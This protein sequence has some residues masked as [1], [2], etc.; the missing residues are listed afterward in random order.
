[1]RRAALV[2]LTSVLAGCGSGGDDRPSREEARTCL[3]RLDL[4]VTP[5]ERSPNDDDGPYAKLDANDVLKG[6]VR[7][8]AAYYDDERDAERVQPAA[9]RAAR[10]VDGVV[11]RHGSVT[12]LWIGG[13][14]HP[15]AE[16]TRDCFL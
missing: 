14:E 7:V 4:H 13:H 10:Q 2:A 3:E 1:M 9:R 8:E 15:L 12:L 16:R 11:E 6:R 5:W